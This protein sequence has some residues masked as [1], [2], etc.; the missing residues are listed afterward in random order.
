MMQH[1]LANPILEAALP[2]IRQGRYS[3]CAIGLSPMTTRPE[4]RQ[5]AQ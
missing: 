4:G 2:M 5:R 1:P 3:A